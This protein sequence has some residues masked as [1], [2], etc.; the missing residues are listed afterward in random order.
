MAD[1]RGRG[2]RVVTGPYKVAVAVWV[3]ALAA[4]VAYQLVETVCLL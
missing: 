2:G 4:A 3:V 1:R